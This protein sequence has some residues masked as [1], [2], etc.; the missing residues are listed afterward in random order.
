MP[1]DLDL[2]IERIIPAP[3]AAV[4]NAWTTP[5]LFEQWWAPAP[6]TTKV[7]AM[8][9]RPGGRF[10]TVMTMPDGQEMVG[11]G[12]FL[13]VDEQER[14]VFTDALTGGWRPS[15]E[16]FMTVAIT[17]TDHADGTLYRGDLMHATAEA[18][19]QHKE[20]G[21]EQGWGAA[22]DQLAALVKP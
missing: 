21:F 14:I 1:N 15:G 17:L 3:R 11:N 19:Q 20:M 4:W 2:S 18:C 12:C 16:A 8:E 10:D 9:L 13:A 6:V 22:L 5:A 7:V